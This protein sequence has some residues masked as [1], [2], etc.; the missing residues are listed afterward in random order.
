MPIVGCATLSS[1]S[2]RQRSHL[3]EQRVRLLALP[4]TPEELIDAVDRAVLEG[5]EQ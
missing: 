3:S 1:L 4:L 2:N 5:L